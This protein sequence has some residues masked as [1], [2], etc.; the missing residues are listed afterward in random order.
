MR[1]VWAVAS[2]S[3]SDYQVVCVVDGDEAA[4][5]AVAARMNVLIPSSWDEYRVESFEMVAGPDEIHA[6]VTWHGSERVVPD[7]QRM[8]AGV[9]SYA[10]FV[11]GAP[12]RVQ[13]LRTDIRKS[14]SGVEVTAIGPTEAKVRKALSDRVAQYLAEQMEVAGG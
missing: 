13:E 5:Q 8:P 14:G 10:R 12:E 7:R 6:H 1:M 11:F 9:W 2:G 3:D 4:A